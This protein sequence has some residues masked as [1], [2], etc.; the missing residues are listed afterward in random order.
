V[1][2][3]SCQ[4]TRFWHDYWLGECPL[5]IQFH[6]LFQIAAKPDIEIAQAYVEGQWDF[7]FRRQLNEIVKI[8]I[9][10]RNC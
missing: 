4:Q 6:R 3:K 5:K 2:I 1:E 8:G 7:K 10:S 9:N